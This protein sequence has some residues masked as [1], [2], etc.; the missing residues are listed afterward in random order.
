M[1]GKSNNAN[2]SRSG[3]VTI[4]GPGVHVKGNISFS[5]FLRIQGEVQGD[6]SCAGDANGTTVVHA[7]GSVTG[8]IRTPNIVVGGRVQG[9][10]HA[11]ES[12][13]IH[14]DA[15]V[16]GDVHYKRLAID[17]G[18]VIE[19]SLVPTAPAESDRS[20]P[21]RRVLR[22]ES[23]EVKALDLP[24]P[25]DRRSTDRFW[26]GRRIGAAVALIAAITAIVWLRRDTATVAPSV[27]TVASEPATQVAPAAL[28]VP[29]ESEKPQGTPKAAPAAVDVP[30]PAPASAPERP[31]ADPDKVVTVQ[32]M[33]ATKPASNFFV[34]TKE[35]VVL[36]R[37]QRK[38]AGDGARI[39][40]SK[41][42]NIR[43]A[44]SESEVVRV[45][46]GRNVEIYFQG[47]KVSPQ[48]VESG[49]WISFIPLDS[50][51][52]SDTK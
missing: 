50:G 2:A 36:F 20:K 38:D 15:C 37:K 34:I 45:A 21:E 14:P 42:A 33:D 26:T 29:A 12:I 9:P 13:E 44:V 43:I 46:E 25:H 6:I 30:P 5:G 52:T 22:S 10:L 39:N 7:S 18:G 51:G 16:V 41:G 28:P 4:I 31:K 24:L 8:M 27:A 3:T 49:V 1:I 23:P 32:G 35:P 11:S 17:L 48:T 19:G 47:R 40:V